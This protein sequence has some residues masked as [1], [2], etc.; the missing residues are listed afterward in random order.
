[1]DTLKNAARPGATTLP[2]TARNPKGL[3]DFVI[4]ASIGG[5]SGDLPTPR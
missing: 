5:R 4:G 2:F 3:Y 1:M